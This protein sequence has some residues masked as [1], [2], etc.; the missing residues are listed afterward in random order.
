MVWTDAFF[1]CAASGEQAHIHTAM[2]ITA[3][4][5]TSEQGTFDKQMIIASIV[6]VGLLLLGFWLVVRAAGKARQG[7]RSYVPKPFQKWTS[8]HPG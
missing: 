3:N 6:I 2:K 4:A 5:V 1:A 7:S 8:S